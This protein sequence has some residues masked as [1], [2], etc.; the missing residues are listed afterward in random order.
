MLARD[1]ILKRRVMPSLLQQKSQAIKVVAHERNRQT[2]KIHGLSNTPPASSL[3]SVCVSSNEP[4]VALSSASNGNILR[5]CTVVSDRPS[6]LPNHTVLFRVKATA[7]LSR[8]VYPLLTP[9]GDINLSCL[10]TREGGDFNGPR[11][12]HYWT[13]EYDC[14]GLYRQYTAGR[15]RRS[16]MW[17]LHVQ[18]PNDFLGGLKKVTLNYSSP[19]KQ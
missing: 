2:A 6:V 7:K 15:C 3:S 12:A 9:E 5:N 14:A 17:L 4:V 16:E 8:S 13:T 1:T 18:V 10:R 19:W 11:S